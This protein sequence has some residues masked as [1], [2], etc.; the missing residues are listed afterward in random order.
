MGCSLTLGLLT[1]SVW[2]Q[3]GA[4]VYSLKSIAVPKPS[5]LNRYVR[6]EKALVVLGKALFWDVQ[7]SSDNRVAC[8]SC[9]FHAGADHRRQNQLSSTKDPVALNWTLA[10][11]DFPFGTNFMAAGH[12]AGSSGMFP[13]QFVAVS[14][15][16][17]PDSGADLDGDA[18]PNI[19]GLNLRQVT[20]RNAPSV[21]NSVF[22]VR[23]F[24]DGRASDLFTGW[25]PF[26]DSDTRAQVL[27]ETN[28]MLV[29]V[30]L[31][32]EHA[33]LASQAVGPPLDGGEMS[34]RGR[35][36]PWLGRKM[37]SA[38]P[39]ALQV[40]SPDDS[41]LGPYA[42]A[43]GRGLAPEHS[44]AALIRAAFRPEYWQNAWLVDENGVSLDS[45]LR[46]PRAP[47]FHQDEYNFPL[48]FGLAVQAYE[49]T[50]I[51]SDSP[52]DR[53]L[54]GQRDALTTVQQ[55]GLEMFQRRACAS[56]HVDPELT[57]AT[58]SGVFGNAGYKGMG[59]D[60]G[61]FNTGVEPTA[62][63]IGAGG[64]D[65]FGML[66]SRAARAKTGPASS[67]GGAFKTP[68]LRNVELT[69]P[70]FH[71]G[72]KSTLE[73]IVD[74]YTFGGDY[75]SVVLRRWG[76]DAYERVAM[77]AL[78]KAFTDDRVRFERA[79]F[80]HPELCVAIGHVGDDKTSV[81]QPSAPRLSLDRWAAIP[82]VGA[83]GNRVPLQTF[84]ELLSGVGNDGSRAHTLTEACNPK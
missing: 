10:S 41:V 47:G 6:D 15:G 77:P 34:Y 2:A 84:E 20:R 65:P 45:R 61:F 83:A 39:L 3:G 43:T 40:V 76:P 64:M 23:N 53:Y 63:D 35:T 9:H 29:A 28:G 50:L 4:P 31:R 82:A 58:Y 48:F 16:G 75:G 71:T 62:N 36:W 42:N 38:Q 33:S 7:L 52:Y 57:L 12:R 30:K 55:A 46:D 21:I 44:Y 81:A 13:R 18:Y 70:Y 59:P 73:Q 80:D 51:S 66:L 11:G 25:T 26:G 24:W 22:N 14:H 1:S 19:H 5:D 37:L 49:S 27:V 79:P 67:L 17:G 69:G 68:S 54:D 8:A 56:C 74:F 72:S 32:I 60:A 78:M